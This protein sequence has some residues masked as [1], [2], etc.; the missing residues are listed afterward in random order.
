MFAFAFKLT[1]K[2]CGIKQRVAERGEEGVT[3]LPFSA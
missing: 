2:K 3:S 1:W